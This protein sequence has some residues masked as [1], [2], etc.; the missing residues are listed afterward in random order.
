M[1]EKLVKEG[2][3]LSEK[4]LRDK[5]VTEVKKIALKTLEKIDDIT[6]KRDKLSEEIKILKMDIDD[7]KEGRLDRIAERQ[8]KDE[9][10]KKIS[11]VVIIKEVVREVVNPWYWPYRVV[12]QYP[13]YQDVWTK[14]HSSC[15]YLPV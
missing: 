1:T 6:K 10:A 2:Y 8:E 3:E 13:V 5:Q 11:V 4:E 12:W 9:E 14:G 7:L 15:K